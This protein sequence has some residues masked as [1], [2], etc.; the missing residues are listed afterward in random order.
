MSQYSTDGQAPG[1]N[2][3]KAFTFGT[4]KAGMTGIDHEKMQKILSEKVNDK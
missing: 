2:R 4:A 1:Y 3:F